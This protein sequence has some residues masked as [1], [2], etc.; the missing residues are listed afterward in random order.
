MIGVGG[1]EEERRCGIPL[2]STERGHGCDPAAG[3]ASGPVDP[4]VTAV[5]AFVARFEVVRLVVCVPS[6]CVRR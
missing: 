3:A 6:I 5:V 4:V 2:V 1:G